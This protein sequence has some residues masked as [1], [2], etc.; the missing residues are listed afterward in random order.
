MTKI[1][2]LT[3]IDPSISNF[4]LV[5]GI[6]D[7]EKREFYPLRTKTIQNSFPSERG[8]ERTQDY[9]QVGRIFHQVSE[10]LASP[11]GEDFRTAE[12]L[13]V[14][15]GNGGEFKTASDSLAK[16]EAVVGILLE[17]VNFCNLLKL[18]PIHVQTVKATAEAGTTGIK[19]QMINWAVMNYPNNRLGFS[20][21]KWSVRTST[22]TTLADCPFHFDVIRH[23]EH[24]ADALAIAVSAV[25]RSDEWMGGLNKSFPREATP[26]EVNFLCQLEAEKGTMVLRIAKDCKVPFNREW[27]EEKG[28]ELTVIPKRSTKT[29]TTTAAEWDSNLTSKK[30]ALSKKYTS[31]VLLREFN[32]YGQRREVFFT[33]ANLVKVIRRIGIVKFLKLLG[34]YKIEGTCP[35]QTKDLKKLIGNRIKEIEKCSKK[36]DIKK[37]KLF[38]DESRNHLALFQN[39]PTKVFQ[40]C[41]SLSRYFSDESW[42]E[43]AIKNLEA[44]QTGTS[45][46][47]YSEFYQQEANLLTAYLKDLRD[48]KRAV[49]KIGQLQAKITEKKEKLSKSLKIEILPDWTYRP[50]KETRGRPRKTEKIVET[51]FE[52]AMGIGRKESTTASTLSLDELTSSE[53]KEMADKLDSLLDDLLTIDEL[54]V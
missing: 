28:A 29:S 22:G 36:S 10:F 41:V 13:A 4:G 26:E 16:S 30:I 39:R 31:E 21:S 50:K 38:F 8:S 23:N 6:V 7:Y 43:T 1:F 20:A 32:K 17:T 11:E 35:E 45:E 24:I 3:A 12:I 49:L 19:E 25:K 2:S 14:E 15:F 51:V 37:L 5:N 44:F 18:V 47:N 34:L 46:V 48:L 27:I 9:F 52:S 40:E 33:D 54:L 42:K 53:K